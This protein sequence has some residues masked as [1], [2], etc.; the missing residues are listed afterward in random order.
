MS[1]II[2][3]I[4]Y[5]YVDPINADIVSK[6]HLGGVEVQTS[7]MENY[8]DL[9]WI[10]VWAMSF[11][12]CDHVEKKP[13]FNQLMNVLENVSHHEMEVFNLLFDTLSKYGEDYMMLELYEMI[14]KLKLNPSVKVRE[15]V[16]KM[17]DKKKFRNLN[18][19]NFLENLQTFNNEK[20]QG[21]NE[22]SKS[23]K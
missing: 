12:Y 14:V 21:V 20:Y 6:S 13:R 15:T 1:Q 7:D 3:S 9:C 10:Q 4:S 22:E 2:K 18:D 17:L 16:M 19:K 11:W 23:K 5:H 8:I